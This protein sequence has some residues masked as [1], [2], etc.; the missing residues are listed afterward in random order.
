[1]KLA[2]VLLSFALQ[3]QMVCGPNG[4]STMSSGSG[5]MVTGNG[6]FPGKNIINAFRPRGSGYFSTSQQMMMA[7]YSGGCTGGSYSQYYP[8]PVGTYYQAPI[9][10]TPAAYQ[11]A[12][13]QQV[14]QY[15]IYPTPQAGTQVTK[16]PIAPGR[17]L[18]SFTNP[19]APQVQTQRKVQMASLTS[20]ATE[21]LDFK[22][23]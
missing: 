16:A 14:P 20:P 3:G 17:S 2:V 13:I 21:Y 15:N 10:Q 4:C 5:M 9:Q 6:W 22:M 1:M 19:P 18:Q 23:Y 12:S 8:V 11:I 7:Q